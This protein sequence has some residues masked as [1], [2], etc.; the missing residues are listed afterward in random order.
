[1]NHSLNINRIMKHAKKQH[2]A[3]IWV[4]KYGLEPPV[5]NDK[6]ITSATKQKKETKIFIPVQAAG[7]FAIF[8]SII[9]ATIGCA[10]VLPIPTIKPMITLKAIKVAYVVAL[11]QK[12]K[13]RIEMI[14]QTDAVKFALPIL[15]AV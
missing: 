14:R 1:M 7:S 10:I 11:I 6:A 2:P 3:N 13:R 5:T 15:S 4:Y 9:S 8:S 12:A